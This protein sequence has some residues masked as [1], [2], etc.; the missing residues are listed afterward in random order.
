MDLALMLLDSLFWDKALTD[1][2]VDQTLERFR[3]LL[4]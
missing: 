2:D 4:G 1:K 3:I